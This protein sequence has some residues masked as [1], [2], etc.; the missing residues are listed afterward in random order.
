MPDIERTFQLRTPETLPGSGSSLLVSGLSDKCDDCRRACG[1]IKNPRQRGFRVAQYSLGK[2]ITL[3]V[4][5]SL[6]SSSG[7]SVCSI[8]LVNTILPLPSSQVSV[9][10]RSGRTASFQT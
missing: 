4:K 5:Y 10:V 8:S 3:L 6:I 1:E 7:K 2:W 9:A